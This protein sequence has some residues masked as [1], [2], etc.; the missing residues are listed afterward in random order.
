MIEALLPAGPS[1]IGFAAPWIALLLAAALTGFAGGLF[2]IGVLGFA[3]Y[4]L[5]LRGDTQQL[6]AE[7]PGGVIRASLASG[8]GL[9]SSLLGIGGGTITNVTMT[10]CGSPIHRAIGTASGMGAIIAVPASIGFV[11]I[12]WGKQGLPVG[13][14]GFVNLPAAAAVIATSVLLAPL[15]VAAAHCLSP[16]L[17]R[18]VFG[19]YL[20]FVGVT[21]IWKS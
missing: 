13:S 10:L 7:M 17:L 6:A 1:A 19:L 16:V 20:I 2:G 8:L 9:I 11:I 5:S 14:L 18:R 3:V 12:G 4:F 15:G 21:M